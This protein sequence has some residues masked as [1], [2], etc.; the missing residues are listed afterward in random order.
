[1][2]KTALMIF[3][4]LALLLAGCTTVINGGPDTPD[5]QS[6]DL[7]G[8]T[9]G[10]ISENPDDSTPD[11]A[12]GGLDKGADFNAAIAEG[13]ENTKIECADSIIT[14]IYSDTILDENKNFKEAK[15]I[16]I[17]GKDG[18]KYSAEIKYDSKEYTYVFTLNNEKGTT[19][20]SLNTYASYYSDVFKILDL[21]MDG[22]ADIQFITGEGTMN[23]VYDF[24]LWDAG[25]MKFVKAECDEELLFTELEVNKDYLQLW[26]RNSASSGV[27]TKYKWDGNRLVKI[28]E[29]EYQAD[30]EA[31]NETSN[32]TSNED[33]NED[34]N[35]FPDEASN[36]ASNENTEWR[37]TPDDIKINRKPIYGITYDQ[38]LKTFGQPIEIKQYQVNK[39]PNNSYLYTCTYDGFECNFYSGEE[40]DSPASTD[41]VRTFDITG[42][43]A[44]LECQLYIYLTK[45]D[46]YN[47]FG[48]EKYYDLNGSEENQELSN[49]K[50]I[51]R[52]YKPEGSYSEY[53]KAA[54][55]YGDTK[56]FDISTAMVLLFYGDQISLDRIVFG[57]PLTD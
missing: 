50:T 17:Q 15:Y 23:S 43:H 32:E 49:I 7:S 22:Y 36:E 2:K 3:V 14:D 46:L 39:S 33:S 41:T 21:N 38:L 52:N 56:S 6:G 9:N 45:E 12:E 28:S 42:T 34:L 20:L 8:A 18:T 47:G 5:K 13:M 31:S 55:V 27:V 11:N 53:S 10:N 44:S 30:D 25:A 29:E 1:M 35:V 40:G 4:A 19:L 57:Y 16:I 48:I 51:L 37:F 54:I 24:F 26:G